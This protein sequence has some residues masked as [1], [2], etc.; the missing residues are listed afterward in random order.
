[1][2]FPL[3]V[4]FFCSAVL[5]ADASVLENPAL[6]KVKILSPPEQHAEVQMVRDGTPDFTIV[7]DAQAESHLKH[8]AWKSIEPAIAVLRENIRK[9]TGKEVEAVDWRKADAVRT[10]HLLL[11]GES[12]LTRKLGIDARK[13]PQ[14]GFLVRSFRNGAAIVGN[15]SSTDRSF[16]TRGPLYM[17]GARKGTLWGAYD[18]LERFFNCRFYYPGP[19]GSV[20]P[21]VAELR[22]PPLA[23]TDAPYFQNRGT[24]YL[25]IDLS[26]IRRSIAGLKQ[27]DL[28]KYY[29]SQRWSKILPFTSMH[30]PYP[31]KWAQSNPDRIESSFFRSGTGHLY[32]SRISH[33]SNY[34]DVTSLQFADNLIDSLKR[35]YATGGKDQQGWAYNNGYYIVFGQCD[36]EL[37]LPEMRN[38]PTVRRENLI[39]QENI[40]HGEGAYFSDVYGRFYRYFAERVKKE[41]PDKKLIIMPY[42]SYTHAPFQKKYYL[43]DNVEAGVCLGKFPRFIRNPEVLA[44]YRDQMNRWY[45]ALGNRPVQML[46]TYNAGNNCFAQAIATQFL[47]EIPKALGKTLGNVE[48][49][50]EFSMWP[51]P[52]PEQGH[53]HF[54]YATYAGMR[55][56]WNPDFDVDAALDEHWTLFYGPEAGKHLKE[57]HRVLKEGFLKYAVPAQN[58]KALFP[59]K[60]LERMEQCLKEAER[61]LKAGSVERR[62]YDLMSRALKFELKSQRGQH[63][64]NPPLSTVRRLFGD[65]EIRIDGKGD[66]PEWEKCVPVPMLEPNGT[67]EKPR[68]P[69]DLRLLWNPNGIYGKIHMPYPPASGN[70]DMWRNSVV[71]L[72]FSPGTEKKVYFQ[73]ALDPENR[74]CMMKQ[75]LKPFLMARDFQWKCRGFRSAS[76]FNE[77]EWTLEF[78]LPFSGLGEPSPKAYQSWRFNFVNNKL[79][80]PREVSA[81][82]MCLGNNHDINLHGIIKFMGKGD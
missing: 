1:M 52:F 73:I 79:S 69:A 38:N 31:E 10:R 39:T 17:L 61:H 58:P 56:M 66:E 3:N 22:L 65:A 80:E 48:I 8:P 5:T 68:Y 75:Q 12:P 11:V 70:K 40:S 28:E 30:S 2:K 76:A 63:A 19:D 7:Y 46:W 62:R 37:Q 59:P 43:P 32:Y 35:F 57:M 64:Y 45:E 82:S 72:F 34:F 4:L 15:D 13:L 14:E 47:G 50:H 44:Q 26:R 36:N 53:W 55:A 77:N 20:H 78:F 6:N 60:T 49:F 67:G 21:A 24:H 27:E 9:A 51:R 16:N 41:F 54:Y 74:A 81:S 25:K 23:Y 29:Q 33:A 18:F 71:E 42:A